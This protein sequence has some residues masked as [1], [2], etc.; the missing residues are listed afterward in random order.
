VLL[1]VH[2]AVDAEGL[3]EVGPRLR[4][5]ARV[6]QNTAKI[7]ERGG[8]LTAVVDMCNAMDPQGL[9]VHRPG[10]VQPLQ[11]TQAESLAR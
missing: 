1:A 4:Q 2:A 5:H 8:N 6:E 7:V 9:L 10:L 3:L 11:S